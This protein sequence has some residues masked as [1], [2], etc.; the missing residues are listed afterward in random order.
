MAT[1]RS[2]LDGYVM[3]FILYTVNNFLLLFTVREHMRVPWWSVAVLTLLESIA[4][5]QVLHLTW[6]G[7]VAVVFLFFLVFARAVDVER[8]KLMYLNLITVAYTTA[9]NLIFYMAWGPSY[10]WAW[11]EV[12]WMLLVY[13]LTMLPV[14]LG[15]GRTV[16]PWL[17][18][19]DLSNARW[20]WAMPAFSIAIMMLVGSSH[21]QFLMTG[22]ER[23]YGL[24]SML[25][26]LLATG[27]SLLIL[28]II[29]RNQIEADHQHDIELMKVQIA[30]QSR[31]H[32]E[33]MRHM[34]EIRIMRHDLRHHMRV[35]TM[36]LN[37]GNLDALRA[38]FGDMEEHNLRLQDNI[39]YSHN[40]IC[41]LVAHHAMRGAKDAGIELVIRCGLPKAFWVSD[42]DLSILLGNLL[43]NAIN[44]C[45]LQA[46]EPRKIK[47]STA[48][49]GDEAF[50]YMENSCADPSN[51]TSENR[52][53]AGLP[54]SGGYGITSIRGVAVKYNGVA[55]F[56]RMEDCFK[57]SVLLYRP[58]EHHEQTQGPEKSA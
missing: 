23:V 46:S 28:E 41:D 24:T 19:I 2:V 17:A 30:S 35:A 11:E 50:I 12:G 5:Y 36:L 43:E 15:M 18:R 44:A 49:H 22:Y 14:A 1:L 51:D 45:R 26:V 34:D 31:R 21:L 39:I 3:V 58:T 8:Y 10:Q 38:F 37:E 9:M 33:V 40:H 42:S 57:S 48:V 53:K 55:S 25:V 7:N 29:R 47:L 20:L 32:V 54:Q 6:M 56:Q 4:V 13:A 52:K 27:I 16:W